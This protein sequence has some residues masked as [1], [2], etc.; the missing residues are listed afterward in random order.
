MVKIQTKKKLGQHFLKNDDI[1]KKILESHEN[2]FNVLEIGPGIGALTKYLVNEVE[3]FKVIE[4]DKDC[5]LELKKEVKSL[6]VIH[7]DI[8]ELN[9]KDLFENKFSIISNLPYNISSQVFFKVL[10]NIEFITEFT[11]LIQKEVAERISSKPGR[12]TFG[13]LSVLTQIY[14]EVKI[15]FEVKPEEFIPPPKVY[16]SL[17][18]GKR[19][20]RDNIGIPFNFLKSIVK[21]AFQNRRKTLRNS[22]KN[23]NLPKSFT[24]NSIFSKRP[25]QLSVDDYIWLSSEIKKIKS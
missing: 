15:I 8:L 7:G 24:S 1:S 16:S 23:L 18:S 13:I 5:I 14:F 12:K 2:R 22:L 17:I 11:F 10:E 20:L 21:Q 19:N 4:I 3:N 6:Y 25:E 9:F